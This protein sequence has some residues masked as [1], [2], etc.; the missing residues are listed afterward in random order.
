MQANDWVYAVLAIAA[1][2]PLH[3]HA[4][5]PPR[6]PNKFPDGSTATQDEM[7]IS[8]HTLQ[9]Y[10]VDVENFVKC[11]EFE[12]GQNRIPRESQAIQHNT[13]IETLRIIAEKFN[14]QARLFKERQPQS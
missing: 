10:R 5:S 13:A 9:R 12:A 7:V 2:V 11:L 3:A 6:A 14:E 8:M 1:L 4:C